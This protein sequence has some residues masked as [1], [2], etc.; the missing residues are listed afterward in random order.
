L[1]HFGLA[2]APASLALCCAAMAITLYYN[3]FSRA[4]GTLWALEEVGQPYDLHFID[5]RN[6]AQKSPELLAL[7]PMGKLPTLV[8]GDVVVTEGAAIAMYL[9][10]RYAPG[11]LSPALDDP[12]RAAYLRWSMFA[13]SVIEP[14]ALAKLSGWQY[15]S[16]QAGWGDFDAI[17]RTIDHAIGDKEF[18]LGDMFSAADIVFGGNLGYMVRFKMI[19]A[20]PTVS[21]YLARLDARPAA[22]RANAKNMAAA[23]EHGLA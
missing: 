2:I 10:D 23:K 6:S 4:A 3:P 11:R 1:R 5:F 8:D 12:R 19:P 13:P 17:V 7:N 15:K 20:S 21:A 22:Q 14:G 16:S 18:L 9:A